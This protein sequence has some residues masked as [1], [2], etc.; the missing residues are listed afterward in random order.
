[1]PSVTIEEGTFGKMRARI[2]TISNIPNGTY[3]GF[4]VV[5][6]VIVEMV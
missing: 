1:M 6:P 4:D 3:E 5:E 2:V